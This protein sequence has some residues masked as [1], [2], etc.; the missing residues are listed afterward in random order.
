M[1]LK[2]S[3]SVLRHT[4]ALLGQDDA[5]WA[6]IAYWLTVEIGTGDC[7]GAELHRVRLNASTGIAVLPKDT[8]HLHEQ[9]S[10]TK[11]HELTRENTRALTVYRQFE[12]NKMSLELSISCYRSTDPVFA[13]VV[14]T[15]LS[16]C[17]SALELLTTFREQIRT[18]VQ[19]IELTCI[20]K[21][22]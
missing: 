1:P 16:R 8:T 4:E 12:C 11:T 3:C 6:A 7:D 2:D 5:V 10:L 21:C 19:Q 18:Y 20:L 9:L 22:L 15:Y 13:C 14:T 17:D